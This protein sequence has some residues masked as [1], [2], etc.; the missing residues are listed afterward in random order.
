MIT[1]YT[2]TTPN[3][4]KVSMALEELGLRYRVMPVNIGR[5]EQHEPDFLKVS[6]NNKIPAIVD[7]GA[8]P[9][10]LAIFESGAIL[11]YLAELTGKLLPTTG[12]ARVKVLEWLFWQVGGL[13]PMLG[14]LGYFAMRAPEPVPPAVDRFA[15]ESKRLIGVLERRLAA[16]AHLGGDDFS[17]ADIA[18][19]PWIAALRGMDAAPIRGLFE[20]ARHV[21]RWCDAVGSRPGVQR[22][23]KVPEVPAA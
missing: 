9:E 15:A 2:W 16:S 14:Q 4:R 13:G 6:P 20:D 21:G 18:A 17:I 7:E 11:I 23:M 12:A 1:L 3:G 8:G 5:G 19:Y 22:G 10:P